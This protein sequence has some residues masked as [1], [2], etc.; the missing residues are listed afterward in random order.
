VMKE[1]WSEV[2]AAGYKRALDR[3]ANEAGGK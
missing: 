1:L 2:Q 3:L